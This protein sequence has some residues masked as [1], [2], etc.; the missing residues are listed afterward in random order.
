MEPET[1]APEQHSD[2][3]WLK[4]FHEPVPHILLAED[5]P[6]L[7]RLIATALRY[8]GFQVIEASDGRDLLDRMCDWMLY[9]WPFE[10]LSLILSDIRMPGLSGTQ[11]VSSLRRSHW[12]TPVILMTAFPDPAID[13]EARALGVANVFSKP[14]EID[15][16]RTA[17]INV[18]GAKRSARPQTDED[19]FDTIDGEFA[20]HPHRED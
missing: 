8:D 18:A 5:D 19:E 3:D 2:G 20:R 12:R 15:D 6:D 7:R 11:V 4:R 1:N 14:F 9:R 13:R 17:V 16:L 10:E